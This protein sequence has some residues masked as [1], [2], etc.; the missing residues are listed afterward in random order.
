MTRTTDRAFLLGTRSSI[1]PTGCKPCFEV[2]KAKPEHNSNSP[3]AFSLVFWG[4]LWGIL[5][6]FLCVRLTT[7]LV[8]IL[9][10]FQSTRWVSILSPKP[11]IRR[12]NREI[13]RPKPI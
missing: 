1:A 8:I 13:Q 11:G 6:A 3:E 9:A 2:N 5:G 7:I 4:G 12:E 10:N